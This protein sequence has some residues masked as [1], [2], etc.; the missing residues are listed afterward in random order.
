MFKPATSNDA[1]DV[2]RLINGSRYFPRTSAK[3]FVE[4]FCSNIDP[5]HRG[6]FIY[7]NADSSAAC[8]QYY[9]HPYVGYMGWLACSPGS[10]SRIIDKGL[11]FMD[12]L[13][14]KSGYGIVAADKFPDLVE[15][16][17]ARGFVK[18]SEE[19][20]QS[21]TLGH[22]EASPSAEGYRFMT[23]DQLEA[24]GLLSLYELELEVAADIPNLP[25]TTRPSYDDFLK[26]LERQR[27]HHRFSVVALKDEEVVAAAQH[28]SGEDGIFVS[29]G[30]GV[31]RHA[32]GQGL[33]VATKL[34]ALRRIQESG[35]VQ[36]DTCNDADNVAMLAINRKIGFVPLGRQCFFKAPARRHILSVE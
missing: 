6:A 7:K 24:P 16:L 1:D 28:R 25:I 26:D 10:D 12:G 4:A 14:G 2:A 36:V 34:E 30:T 27:R 11:N 33:A 21:L 20:Y 22:F 29:S 35:G 15:R 5:D 13:L 8:C 18:N 31:R 19:V 32:R 23:L 17:E 9:L 3:H